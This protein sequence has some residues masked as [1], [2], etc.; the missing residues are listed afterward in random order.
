MGC[1][2]WGKSSTVISFLETRVTQVMGFTRVNG[3]TNDLSS[4]KLHQQL[5]FQGIALASPRLYP[6][7]TH[8]EPELS[9]H[10][11]IRAGGLIKKSTT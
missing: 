9:H 10:I 3:C 1:W 7:L 8:F 6:T 5:R 4:F 2:V 11:A